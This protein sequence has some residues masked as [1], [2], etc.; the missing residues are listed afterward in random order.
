MNTTTWNTIDTAPTNLP[1]LVGAWTTASR[2]QKQWQSTV[3]EQAVF[4]HDQHY[5]R[6]CCPGEYATSYEVHFA[7]TH[8]TSI[9]NPPHP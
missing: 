8:W 6:L 4:E 3:A 2:K 7:P 5:W 9:P 1:I